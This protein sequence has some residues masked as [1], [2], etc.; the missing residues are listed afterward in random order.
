LPKMC[1]NK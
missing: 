1:L